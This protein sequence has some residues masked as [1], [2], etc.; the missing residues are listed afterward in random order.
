[1][2]KELV[3]YTGTPR[4]VQTYLN[5]HAGLLYKTLYTKPLVMD[6]AMGKKVEVEVVE[7]NHVLIDGKY[8]E[9]IG[10]WE[11]LAHIVEVQ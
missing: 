4:V 5:L 6:L 7:L 11:S 3:A 10:W 9:I 1:M 2:N 8:Y